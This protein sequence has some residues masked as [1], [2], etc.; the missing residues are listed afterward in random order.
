MSACWWGCGHTFSVSVGHTNN[1]TTS[2]E[3]ALSLRIK[4]AFSYPVKSSIKPAPVLLLE[5][6]PEMC[7]RDLGHK[8][9]LA[10]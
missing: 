3:S 2:T 5:T 9:I 7:S 10:W 6:I 4:L 8:A 1:C